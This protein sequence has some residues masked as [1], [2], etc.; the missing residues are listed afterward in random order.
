VECPIESKSGVE[1]IVAYGAG[2]LA[3]DVSFTLE[4]HMEVCAKCR[5]IVEAQREVWLALDSW[6][7]V[8]VSP[9]FNEVLYHRIAAEPRNEWWRRPFRAQWSWRP[10]MPVAAACAA[11]IAAFLLQG[12][13]ERQTPSQPAQAP[14]IEQVERALDDMD[15]LKQ[16]GV[17]ASREAPS[18]PEQT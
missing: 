8:P 14:Q 18:S 15:M 1:L 3:P 4:R 2:T 17:T 5:E 12:P 10:A 7:P 13:I 6:S 9:D 16:L 11:L